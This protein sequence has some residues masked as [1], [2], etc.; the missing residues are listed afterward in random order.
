MNE[1][2]AWWR[3]GRKK[4]SAGQLPLF[5]AHNHLTH[6][7]SPLGGLSSIIYCFYYVVLGHFSR[8]HL[9][10]ALWTIACQAPLSMGILQAGI[11]EWVATPSCSVSSQPRD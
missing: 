4:K 3:R 11:L 8:V 1:R 10:V 6:C 7:L 9:F 5:P 2:S